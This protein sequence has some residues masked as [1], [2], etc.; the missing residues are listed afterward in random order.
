MKSYITIVRTVSNNE[1]NSIIGHLYIS[2]KFFCTTLENLQ[3]SIPNGYYTVTLTWSPRFKRNLPLISVVPGR[4]G[5][6]IHSGNTSRDSQG[7]ILVGLRDD[8]FTLK[9]SRLTLQKL[10]DELFKGDSKSFKYQ[11]EIK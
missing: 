8:Y 5:I 7:C 4:R 1:N 10:I 6:R 11:L 3:K 9:D 2:G